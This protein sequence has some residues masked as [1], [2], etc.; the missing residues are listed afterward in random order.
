MQLQLIKRQVKYD[1]Q[2]RRGYTDYTDYMKRFNSW[3]LI[4]QFL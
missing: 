4:R 2:Y 1:L 3:L